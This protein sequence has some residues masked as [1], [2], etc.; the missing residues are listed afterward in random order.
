LNFVIKKISNYGRGKNVNTYSDS[1]M[2]YF[3]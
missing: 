2:T 3:P 1:V